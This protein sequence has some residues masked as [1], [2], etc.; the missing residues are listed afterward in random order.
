MDVGCVTESSKC[1]TKKKDEGVVMTLKDVKVESR[2]LTWV[3][4]LHILGRSVNVGYLFESLAESG[5]GEIPKT[6][7]E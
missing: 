3:Y 7:V 5:R 1:L 4:F 2:N 6:L